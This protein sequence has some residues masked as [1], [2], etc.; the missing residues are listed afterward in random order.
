MSHS[1]SGTVTRARVLRSCARRARRHRVRHSPFRSLLP[2]AR[3]CGRGARW[4]WWRRRRRRQR[5]LMTRAV[6]RTRDR[7]HCAQ[8][9]QRHLACRP[10]FRSPIA[11]GVPADGAEPTARVGRAANDRADGALAAEGR[12]DGAR[13]A[14][15][16]ADGAYRARGQRPGRRPSRRHARGTRS[17]ARGARG[18]R[19]S[20]RGARGVRPW[21][22]RRGARG[23][24]I[25]RDG[26]GGFC[27]HCRAGRG[28]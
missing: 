7:C 13:A 14:E 23:A 4:R 15:G 17:T 20:R 16:R 25:T 3:V 5:E 18:G 6:M 19:Q 22:S 28:V 2:L 21:P 27:R 10:S 8:R 11:D 24:V 9:T 1:A 12:A 26:L